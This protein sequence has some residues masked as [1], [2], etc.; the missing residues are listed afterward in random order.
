MVTYKMGKD[1]EFFF[2]KIQ[3]FMTDLDQMLVRINK[4]IAKEN[5]AK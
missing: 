2:C 3:W 1:G 5:K 4:N